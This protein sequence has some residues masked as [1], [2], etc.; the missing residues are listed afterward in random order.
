MRARWALLRL[1]MLR[2]LAG[3]ALLASMAAPAMLLT[4]RVPP[5]M[6]VAGCGPLRRAPPRV[7]VT[8]RLGDELV[9]DHLNW[10]PEI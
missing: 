4:G 5:L 7:S 3:L 2:R 10:M 9:E 8:T 1:G 6:D